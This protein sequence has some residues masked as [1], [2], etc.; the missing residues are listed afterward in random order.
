MQKSLINK[1][2]IKLKNIKDIFLIL[3]IYKYLHIK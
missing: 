2:L 3:F 1:L